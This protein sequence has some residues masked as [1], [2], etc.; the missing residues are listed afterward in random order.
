MNREIKKNEIP[1]NVINDLYFGEE[2]I[3]LEYKGDI[4]WSSKNK[5]FEIIKTI[6]AMANQRGGGTIVIGVKDD[7]ER[8]GL[9]V[10]NYNS[11]PYK[12]IGDFINARASQPVYCEMKKYT[13]TDKKDNKKK[14]FVYVQITPCKEIPTIYTG[15]QELNNNN[16]PAYSSNVSLRTGALYIRNEIVTGNKEISTP[17]EW[18]K[19]LEEKIRQWRR[20]TLRRYFLVKTKK[21]RNEYL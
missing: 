5:K 19:L 17:Q 6:F 7:G 8:I 16:K 18:K 20:E 10:K 11:Y 2:R 9:S 15:K 21:Q 1:E 12:G 14:R 3:D 4:P 13:H